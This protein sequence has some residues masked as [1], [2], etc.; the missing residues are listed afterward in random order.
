MA[1]YK[2]VIES[3]IKSKENVDLKKRMA[4]GS[5]YYEQENTFIKKMVK[6][7]Y[8]PVVND[9]GDITGGQLCNDP[10]RS[11]MKLPSG[12]LKQIVMEKVNYSVNGKMSLKSEDT[13]IDLKAIEKDI[14][15]WKRKFK[16][17][18]KEASKK[19]F[20]YFE[21]FVNS[22]GNFDY[23]LIPSEQ[24]IIIPEVGDRE[25]IKYVIR[26]Y[27][28]RVQDTDGKTVSIKR[29]D[30]TTDSM[31]YMY[32]N[33]EEVSSKWEGH[34]Y[35]KK[36]GWHIAPLELEPIN[37]KPLIVKSKELNHE[38]IESRPET[39]GKP[40]IVRLTNNDEEKTDLEPIKPYIDAYDITS[41]NMI[42]NVEDIQEAYF[43][44]KGY[45][46]DDLSETLRNLKMF[47]AIATDKEGGFS[48]ET[49]AIPI[50]A[51]KAALDLLEKHIYTS[52]MAVNPMDIEGNVT[53]VR[54]KALFKNLEM[55]NNDFETEVNDAMTQLL[56]FLN[57]YYEITGNGNPFDYK[58]IEIVFNRA[59][60]INESEMLRVNGE[61][62]GKVSEETRLTNHP[63]VTN[64]QAEKERIK[65]DTEEFISLM[66]T[67]PTGPIE[68]GGN[69]E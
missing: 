47:K 32:I 60:I 58:A 50:E 67:E 57:R 46:G 1:D 21:P 24:Y 25:S 23:K 34:I 59:S 27:Q 28:E 55:K 10:Y 42:N 43:H 31:K 2:N 61:Q 41:S 35:V 18:A 38:V 33:T 65:E 54:I 20:G 56:Y 68:E 63:W 39:W 13:T 9:D 37:P 26:Y 8:M 48:S 14:G 69:V 6:E 22:L 5:K 7:F 45:S 19:A 3:Y 4:E 11:N 30:L 12:F 40:P 36:D 16:K 64:A 17:I 53:N 44:V 52:G 51:K 29:A 62:Q 49:V 15:K 66:P